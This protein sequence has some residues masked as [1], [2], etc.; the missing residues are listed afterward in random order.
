MIIYVLLFS[1]SLFLIFVFFF[2]FFILD[3]YVLLEGIL[4]PRHLL[5][6]N[7]INCTFWLVDLADLIPVDA[8]M[9]LSSLRWRELRLLGCSSSILRG[10]IILG[11]D[12]VDMRLVQVKITYSL[13]NVVE[14][15]VGLSV[16]F[17]KVTVSFGG[18]RQAIL[19]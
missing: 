1:V 8:V 2:K 4:E 9:N 14:L 7:M 3:V 11:G 17:V 6:Y 18:L 13:I 15:I 5:I 16:H 12:L 19:W 10:G